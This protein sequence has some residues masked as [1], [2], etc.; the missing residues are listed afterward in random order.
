[1]G[2]SPT[3]TMGSEQAGGSSS[4]EHRVLEVNVVSRLKAEELEDPDAGSHGGGAMEEGI[5]S[6]KT[7]TREKE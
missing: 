7:T 1:M 3:L 4:V 5:N 2:V 6:T